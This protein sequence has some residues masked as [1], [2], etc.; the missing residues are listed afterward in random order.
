M[1]SIKTIEINDLPNYQDWLL[2]DVRERDEWDQG[3]MD[4]AVLLPLSELRAE[5][6][7]LSVLPQDKNLLLYCQRG[8][9]SITAGE[10]LQAQGYN[11]V[12]M[13]GGYCGV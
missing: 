10:I 9:R 8:R 6:A 3:H 12:S 13:N 11:V 2:V 1:N 4:N 5:T 7:D